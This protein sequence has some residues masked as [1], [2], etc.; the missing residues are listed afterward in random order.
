VKILILFAQLLSS[1]HDAFDAVPWPETFKLFAI[2]ISLPFTLDFLSAFAP[3][4]CRLSLFPLD[5][6][7]LHMLL[8]PF[9]AIAV[10][11]A[12]VITTKLPCCLRTAGDNRGTTTATTKAPPL[13]TLTRQSRWEL[14]IKIFIFLVQLMYPSLAARI[15]ST[16]RCHIY[17]GAVDAPV[18]D[19][20]VLVKCHTGRHAV[21]EGLAALFMLLY[22][23]GIPL[24]M[25]IV[26]WWHR[27]HLNDKSSQRHTTIK[28]MLGALYRQFT[29]QFW[30]FGASYYRF[31]VFLN[32]IDGQKTVRLVQFSSLVL[33]KALCRAYCCW[34]GCNLQRF[35]LHAK[36]FLQKKRISHPPLPPSPVPYCRTYHHHYQNAHDGRHVCRRT[37]EPNP[38][39]ARHAHHAHFHAHH[40]QARAFPGQVGRLDDVP[41]VARDHGQHAG[42]ICAPHGQGQLAAQF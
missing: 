26:L 42:W 29:P 33:L 19:R 12:Y 24:S 27:K 23:A 37:R 41:C 21:F 39:R 13:K 31:N 22:V 38:A 15:F 3:S 28:Y 16:F 7:L 11:S 9:L 18:L 2:R 4:N 35:R 34:C 25:F 36:A 14:A 10:F 32:R 5:A 30:Y 1:M 17:G 20:N 8:L 40:A 6:F